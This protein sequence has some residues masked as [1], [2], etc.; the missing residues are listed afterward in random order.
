MH[1]SICCFSL[2][3]FNHLVSS[4]MNRGD[5]LCDT[6]AFI[7]NLFVFAF[8]LSY[9]KTLICDTQPQ[10]SFLSKAYCSK[11]SFSAQ[12]N[13]NIW[14]RPHQWTSRTKKLF[15]SSLR[16][17]ELVYSLGNGQASDI[18]FSLHGGIVD[19]HQPHKKTTVPLCNS[20]VKDLP[21]LQY[22]VPWRDDKRF[23]SWEKCKNKLFKAKGMREVR[24]ACK[25][26]KS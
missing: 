5:E 9:L 2:V 26:V 21:S 10:G 20:A 8:S 23:V 22:P 4:R 12:H 13:I 19:P 6:V 17:G 15:P 11:S 24:A 14:F 7:W 16:F 18:F 1:L 25:D 3:S